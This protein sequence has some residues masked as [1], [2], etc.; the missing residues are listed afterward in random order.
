[1]LRELRVRNFAVLEAVVVPLAPGLNVLTGETGAG[2]SMLIDAILLIRG[3]RAQGDVIRA[4]TETATVEAVFDVEPRG[5]VA[6][7]LDEAGLGLDDGQLVLRRELSRAGRHRAFANDAPVTVGLLE[8]L[9]DHLVEV[10][11]QHEHQRL[12]EPAR[13]LELLDR[14]ADAED[15]REEVGGLFAKFREARAEMERARAAERDRAQREDLLRFQ[16][17]ELDA[18][19]LRSGEEAELRAELR[20]AQ[21]A[22]KLAGGLAEAAA[23]LDDDRDAATGRLARAARLL[24]DLGRID[25]AFAAPVAGLDAAQ[26]HLEEVLAALRALRADVV[27]EPGRR[28]AIDERLDALTRLKRKYGESAEAM[29]G[30]REEAAAELDRL[31]RHEEILAEQERLLGELR[32]ELEAAATALADRRQGAV[33]RLAP[34]VER[35][36]RAL[37]MER[38]VFRVALERAPLEA[39]GARGLDR[40]EFRLST[41]PGEEL[42]PLARVAS[43]GELSRTMLAL[44]AVLARADRVPTMVFDEVDAGIGGRVASVVAQKLAAAAEGRQ[45]LCVTHLAP[46]AAAAQQHLRVVKSVRGGRTRVAAEPLAGA[47]RVE[48]IARMLGGETVTDTARGHARALLDAAGGGK[49]RG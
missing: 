4:D 26:A 31:G 9:G 33:E 39:I 20:R 34:R 30:F 36:L 37:G 41:N 3:A 13:Q 15:L 17:G 42:R 45:V 23:L 16:V 49:R 46:I 10:H 14:F 6:A 27:V 47:A 35:E 24:G 7:L 5:P 40:V 1:M 44:K 8:R 32:V 25:P 11:G 38:A 21:H 22:E 18:A 43:G 29:L 19:R 12:L 28:E 48:E 2:K